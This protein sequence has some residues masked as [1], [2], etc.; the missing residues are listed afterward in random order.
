MSSMIPPTAS[1]VKYDNPVLVSK[2]TDKRSKVGMIAAVLKPRQTVRRILHEGLSK[3]LKCG[4]L[5]NKKLT[6]L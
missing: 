4:C 2:N 3:G 6:S 1:L 5:C